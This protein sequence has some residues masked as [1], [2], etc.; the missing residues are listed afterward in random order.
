[1]RGMAALTENQTKYRSVP[2]LRSVGGSIPRDVLGIIPELVA[3]TTRMVPFAWTSGGVKVA[4]EDPYDT[5]LHHI[6]EKRVGVPVIPHAASVDALDGALAQYGVD[7]RDDVRMLLRDARADDAIDALVR[8]AQANDAA[9]IVMVFRRDGAAISARVDGFLV[10]VLTAPASA[11]ILLLAALR[12]RIGQPHHMH[13]AAHRGTF[14]VAQGRTKSTDDSIAVRCAVMPA[15]DGERAV[16]CIA[17]AALRQQSIETL[18]WPAHVLAIVRRALMRSSGLTVIVGPPGAGKT[19]AL[20]A[21]VRLLARDGTSTAAVEE[22]IACDLEGVQQLEAQR[23]AMTEALRAILRES[24]AVIAVDALDDPEAVAMALHAALA[25]RRVIATMDVPDAATA[26]QRL[27]AAHVSSHVLAAVP[28]VIVVQ[29]LVRA[30]CPACVVAR[31]LTETEQRVL[32]ADAEAMTVFEAMEGVVM[33][34]TVVPS[35][36]G[37][38][39]C[40]YTGYRGFACIAEALDSRAVDQGVDAPRASLLAAGM[41]RALA[42]ET[43]LQEVLRVCRS[44]DRCAA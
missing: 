6:I 9:D 21:L 31:H 41:S 28:Y 14:R 2:M 34:T 13:R 40:G 5:A 39:A 4:M 33:Q 11:G 43:T 17:N 16:L 25:G 12:Q 30:A 35:V 32:A 8:Y 7:S 1:M 26:Q 44:G 27:R 36:R 10:P 24:P 23:G 18:G 37:C 15:H 19:T 22:R 3:R 42:H 20:Y 38:D 29:R